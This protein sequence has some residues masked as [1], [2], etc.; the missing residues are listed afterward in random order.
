MRK[1]KGWGER[2]RE[3]ERG[4]MHTLSVVNL[5]LLPMHAYSFTHMHKHTLAHTFTHTFTHNMHTHTH[6]HTLTLSDVTITKAAPSTGAVSP[7]DITAA[8]R[9]N[10]VLVS[11]MLA[12]NETGVIQPVREV[13]RA[14]R[15]AERKGGEGGRRILV[16][17]DA[18]QVYVRR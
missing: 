18:A 13:V 1:W 14:V 7:Q 8:L 9:P 6:I 11:L 5:W 2:G 12:N 17:T 16:H 4:A 10:T 3:R 15:V